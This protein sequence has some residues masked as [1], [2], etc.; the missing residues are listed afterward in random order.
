[1]GR[2]AAGRPPVPACAPAAALRA[3]ATTPSLP[4]PAPTP[5]PAP[6]QA[7]PQQ[8][9]VLD[10]GHGGSPDN[11]HP[12]VPFDPGAVAA[13]GLLEKDVALDL[14][15]RLRSLLE[16]DGVAVVL[17]RDSD[18]W[19]SIEDRSTIANNAH[20]DVFVSCHLNG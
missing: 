12:D 2:R 17:T 8:V 1:M 10:A 5:A 9:V 19:M 15:R 11:A 3:A 16:S 6:V 14:V 18:V 20:A 13:N 7:P 4:A